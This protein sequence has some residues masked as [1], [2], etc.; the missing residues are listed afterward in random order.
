M[1]FNSGH[2]VDMNNREK[3]RNGRTSFQE[4]N[5]DWVYAKR[6]KEEIAFW[7]KDSRRPLSKK[8]KNKI[9][10]NAEIDRKKRLINIIVSAIVAVGIF[11]GIYFFA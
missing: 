2:I 9:H 3:E 4:N 1:S 8:I 11:A 5:R 6:K 7:K 10:K